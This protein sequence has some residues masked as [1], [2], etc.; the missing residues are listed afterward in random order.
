MYRVRVL[1]VIC[2]FAVLASTTALFAQQSS[3]ASSGSASSDATGSD[4]KVVMKVGATKLTEGQFDDIFADFSK[5]NEGGPVTTRKAIGESLASALVFSQQ[6]EAQGV[7]KDPEIQ[8]QIEASRIQILSN[9]EFERMEKQATPTMQEV[10]AFY[11]AHLDDF[12]EVSIRRLFVYKQTASSSGHG[13][14]DAEAKA[15]AEQ[16]RKVLASGGDAKALI[17]GT[18]DMIDAD[19]ITF[20]RDELTGAMAQAFD[21][22]EGEWSQVADSPDAD[23]FFQVVKKARLTL[24]QAT[25]AIQKKLQAQ[26]L[27]EAVQALKNKTG[28]WMDDAYFSGPLTATK[29]AVANSS[30]A[31]QTQEKR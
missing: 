20:K 26:K 22:K 28:I 3:A 27:R 10:A 13:L 6:A 23:L 24:A 1:V 15:R 29:G 12:D 19:P 21:M 31:K 4:Q 5:A 25:P 9:A 18:K 14:P 17:A 30:S 16:I 7:D 8:R 11:N 2:L